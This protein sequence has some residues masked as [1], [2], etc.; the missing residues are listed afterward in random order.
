[1]MAKN[2]ASGG[3]FDSINKN[4]GHGGISPWPWAAQPRLE[5]RLIFR[6]VR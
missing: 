3:L 6:F 1:M 2:F 4:K 5:P